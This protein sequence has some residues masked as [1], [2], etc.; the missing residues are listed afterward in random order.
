MRSEQKAENLRVKQKKDSTPAEQPSRQE[1]APPEG[2]V[3][4]GG[5]IGGIGAFFGMLAA[6]AVTAAV[7]GPIIVIGIILSVIVSIIGLVVI[8]VKQYGVVHAT[9]SEYGVNWA[10]ILMVLPMILTLVDFFNMHY[11]N[12]YEAQ[13]ICSSFVD[14]IYDFV[15]SICIHAARRNTGVSAGVHAVW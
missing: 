13:S 14:F 2:V 9:L 15:H 8:W 10:T 5:L 3:S 4:A 7:M 1:Q 11:K 12:N 6:F